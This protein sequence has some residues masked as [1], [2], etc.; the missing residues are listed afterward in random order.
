MPALSLPRDV[1][2]LEAAAEILP[3][4]LTQLV[5]AQARTHASASLPR[6]PALVG[7]RARDALRSAHATRLRT[8]GNHNPGNDTDAPT[9]A[10]AAA[11][12]FASWT[13]V[14][15][16]TC[17]CYKAAGVCFG[18]PIVTSLELESC[19]L[20]PRKRILETRSADYQVR[21][22]RRVCFLR[23]TEPIPAVWL[24]DATHVVLF[25]WSPRFV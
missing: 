10:G 20:K 11:L 8:G 12:I 3:W 25:R 24:Y 4:R 5:R 23:V 16:A 9:Q 1:L 15:T 14:R 19:V 13:C 18:S 2:S 17:S 7:C 21:H 6:W 22:H